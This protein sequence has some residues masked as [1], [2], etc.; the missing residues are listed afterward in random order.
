MEMEPF[1]VKEAITGQLKGRFPP[2]NNTKLWGR[3]LW[4]YLKE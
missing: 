3:E 4:T 1:L 2:G